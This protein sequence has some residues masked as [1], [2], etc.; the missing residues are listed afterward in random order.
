MRI[1]NV[2][3]TDIKI[4]DLDLAL[5]PGEMKDLSSFDPK[6]IYQHKKL[7]AYFDKGLLVNIGSSTPPGSIAS[8]KSTRDK[9]S[10]LGFSDAIVKQAKKPSNPNSNSRSAINEL[11]KK[12]NPREKINPMPQH[13]PGKDR[14]H[15]QYQKNMNPIKALLQEELT[16]RPKLK[17]SETFVP[18]QITP[19]GVMTEF[20]S[21]GMI[22]SAILAGKESILN[23]EPQM[24]VLETPET[25]EIVDKDGQTYKVNL[26]EVRERISKKCLGYSSKGK[27]CKKY[28]VLGFKSCVTHMTTSERK[29]FERLKR[30]GQQ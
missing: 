8:L 5:A 1:K 3:S 11:L 7:N 21:N 10:K 6:V 16:M 4:P 12:N 2:S 30:E 24:V 14:F 22:P 28:A 18:I 27:P 19:D 13:D 29:E 20:G 15:E 25:I 26:D 17:I 23:A 9:I